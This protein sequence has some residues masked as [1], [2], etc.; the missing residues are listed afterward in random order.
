MRIKPM[1]A[2]PGAEA[3]QA[4]VAKQIWIAPAATSQRQDRL[5][6]AEGQRYQSLGVAVENSSL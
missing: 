1:L 2:Q 6:E 4:R 5:Q 3:V